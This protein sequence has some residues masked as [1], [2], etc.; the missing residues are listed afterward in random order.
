M[1]PLTHSTYAVTVINF[2]HHL[3]SWCGWLVSVWGILNEFEGFGDRI[4]SNDMQIYSFLSLLQLGAEGGPEWTG[5]LCGSHWEK[6]HLGQTW[7]SAYRVDSSSTLN[8]KMIYV[9]L[10]CS[11]ASHSVFKSNTTNVKKKNWRRLKELLLMSW[12]WI[13]VQVRR[14]S[15]WHY[16]L[17]T[18]FFHSLFSA[19]G[20]AGWTRWE[21]CIMLTT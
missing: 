20:S 14:T 21:G 5:V 7:V 11:S 15:G 2:N 9:V 12:S 10:S 4:C 3:F 18:A 8:A 19:G 6:N 1:T 17:I 13:S 16:Q